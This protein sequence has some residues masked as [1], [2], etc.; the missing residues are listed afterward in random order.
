MILQCHTTGPQS[1][2]GDEM[3]TVR[4]QKP[5]DAL[6]FKSSMGL[7][8]A[9]R[10]DILRSWKKVAEVYSGLELT[11]MAKDRPVALSGLANE[12]DRALRA[13]DEVTG[14][15]HRYVCGLW[16]DD[17][18]GLLWDQCEPGPRARVKGIPTWSWASMATKKQ[19]VKGEE[20]LTGMAVRWIPMPGERVCRAVNALTVRVDMEQGRM[21]PM[22]RD[23]R[24][25]PPGDHYG[26]DNRFCMMRL[27]GRLRAVSIDGLF[28][29]EDGINAA[30]RLTGFKS[31]SAKGLWRRVAVREKPDV[32]NGWASLEHPGYQEDGTGS[33]AQIR[34]VFAF[35]V[36]RHMAEGGLGFGKLSDKQP[37]FKVL[38]LKRVE[39]EGHSDC[40]ERLGVGALFGYDVESLYEAAGED[41]IW[42]V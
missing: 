20:E 2:T 8:L 11:K 10:I 40:Y 28:D 38:Y 34:D 5:G 25:M 26:N 23:Y 19:N 12:F 17:S 6:A 3:E 15:S 21:E 24:P 4:T 42:L 18:A 37:A 22:F 39:V 33:L 14:G 29:S 41:H 27:R 1:V 31:D 36:S 13:Q 30:A 16:F 35:F 9:T 7:G 32:I